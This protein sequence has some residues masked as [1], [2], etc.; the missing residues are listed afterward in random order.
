MLALVANAL[1]LVRFRFAERPDLSGELADLLFVTS[2]DD[3]VRLIRASDGQLLG[4]LLVQFVGVS[5][6]ELQRVAANCR[7]V[8]DADD[9]QSLLVTL[10]DALDHVGDQ[11]AGQS[12]E[13]AGG[14]FV[15]VS[16]HGDFFAVVAD[17]DLDFRAV[18]ERQFTL[19]TFDRDH[20]IGDRHGGAVG[21][22]N[23][24]A[25]DTTHEERCWVLGI[26]CWWSWFRIFLELGLMPNT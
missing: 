9:F 18:L 22:G 2:L 1:A 23:G 8:A 14:T 16:G 6:A 10:G 24:F 4:D 5:D 7:Q 13:L 21:D 25:A 12:V 15:A 26:R 20:P 11:G 3:D 17:G 19:G